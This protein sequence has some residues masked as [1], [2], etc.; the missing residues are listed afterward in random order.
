M[1]V[2]PRDLGTSRRNCVRRIV[3][4]AHRVRST[5]PQILRRSAR[6]LQHF[7]GMTPT[8]LLCPIDFSPGADNA[9]RTAV[10]LARARDAEL[11]LLHAWQAPMLAM[12]GEPELPAG[13]LRELADDAERSLAAAVV[14][15]K[16]LGATRVTSSLVKG[17]PW[18]Q[19]VETLRTDSAYELVVMGTHGRSG[20]TRFLLGSVAEKVVRHAPCSVL[21]VHEADPA[22]AFRRV[23]CPVDFSESAHHAVDLA[24]RFV[25]P[26]GDVTLLHVLELPLLREGEA[27]GAELA[28]TLDERATGRLVAWAAELR[29]KVAVPVTTRTRLGSAGVQILAVLDEAP[30]FELV[31]IGSHGRTG[32][33]RALLGSVAEK[34]VRHA[35]C[36]VLVARRRI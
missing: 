25:A 21:A 34:I 36:A 35:P 14:E 27:S 33:R 5:R 32:L 13:I 15:A 9:L 16:Q 29:A 24:G 2:Q 19:I 30:P 6:W 18:D 28:V 1:P 11:V 4:A 10:R 22:T 26:G 31:V 8:K 7:G 17:V 23:L 20:V 12:A 3:R